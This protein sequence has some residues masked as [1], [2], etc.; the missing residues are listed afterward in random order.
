MGPL[1]GLQR[2][3]PCWSSVL[4]LM[5]IHLWR[6]KLACHHST[7]LKHKET[8]GSTAL[9]HWKSWWSLS[10]NYYLTYLVQIYHYFYFKAVKSAT[11]YPDSS[12][13]WTDM[14]LCHLYCLD[15][16]L[17]PRGYIITNLI[18]QTS[19]IENPTQNPILFFY[20][21]MFELDSIY[22]FTI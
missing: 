3:R 7:N 13:M 18:N 16:P 2:G 17:P 21:K 22:N 8:G 11:Y 9:C 19:K 10:N 4:V 6:D 12:G 5:L 14:F 15:H 20:C 1:S